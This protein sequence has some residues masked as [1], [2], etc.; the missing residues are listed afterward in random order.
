MT[1][2]PIVIVGAGL[3]GLATA[4]RLSQ[5]G[6]QVL[7]LEKTG[8]IGGRNGR[9]QVGGSHFDLGPTLLMMQEPLRRLFED[10]GERL[11]EHLTIT[12]CDPGYRA[13]FAD[14]T[15]IEA[16]HRR[17]EM[18][19]RI[20]AFAGVSEARTFLRFL[21][22]VAALYRES[23]PRFVQRNY[24][25]VWDF[26]GPA[27]I[28]AALRHRMLGN[29]ARR[30]NRTFHDP[31]LRMLFSFQSMYLGLSPFEAPWVY[32]V[33]AHMEFG[34]GIT[35][36]QG[37]LAAISEKVAQLA[38]SRGA[39][40][41]LH[42]EVTQIR[43]QEVVLAG[44][45]RIKASLVVCNADLPYAEQAL[46]G[47]ARTPRRRHSCSA[48]VLYLDYEGELP[49]RHHN[50]FFSRDFRATLDA[51]FRHRRLPEDPAFYVCASCKSDAS[52]APQ[53]YTNLAILVPTPNLE[54]E[55]SAE[56]QMRL[57]DLVFQRLARDAEFDPERVRAEA[58]MTPLDWKS[59]FN[60]EQG[61]AFGLSHVLRQSAYFRPTNHSRRCPGVYF[62]GASTVPGNGIPMVL[63]SAQLA[64]ERIERDLA[65]AKVG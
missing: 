21:D 61:A 64:V 4:L 2:A 5:K 58:A 19:R 48:L 20:A 42:R 47:A 28:A 45:E 55:W 26:F 41:R 46:L 51:I 12:P 30:V 31:R 18:V 10:V 34:E 52:R 17:E 63:I 33:L 27:P 56:G 59:S 9:L 49:L 25:G 3:G 15:A 22:D 60:L 57:R 43:D 39:E 29:L 53:G 24:F 38:Q 1:R 16:T 23:V 32:A 8:N 13:W 62:V 54:M 7:V 65:N 40:I 50:V 36:V 37:G 44:G 11:E 35:Y 14:G 6:H